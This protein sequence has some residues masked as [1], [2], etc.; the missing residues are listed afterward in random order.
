MMFSVPA[1]ANK[2]DYAQT[3]GETQDFSCIGRNF[4]FLAYEVR[5]QRKY[6]LHKVAGKSGS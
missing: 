5:P 2:T 3:S 1:H 6:Y 4:A